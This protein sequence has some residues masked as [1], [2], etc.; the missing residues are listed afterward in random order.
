[1]VS[2]GPGKGS[3]VVPWLTAG[4][5]DPGHVRVRGPLSS[6][7]GS[8]PTDGH[9]RQSAGQEL[10][11]GVRL[12]GEGCRHGTS[13]GI[14]Q[15]QKL[16]QVDGRGVIGL[17]LPAPGLPTGGPARGPVTTAGPPPWV[18]P[19]RPAPYLPERRSE[20][21]QAVCSDPICGEAQPDRSERQRG[22]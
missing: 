9:D 17:N 7:T 12:A 14:S 19:A 5:R 11:I 3:E 4:R 15:P 10:H 1:M 22:R 18:A 21:R 20:A 8:H 13:S 6:A 16:G 2:A